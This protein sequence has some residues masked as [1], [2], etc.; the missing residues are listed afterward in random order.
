M[1]RAAR[2]ICQDRV[3]ITTSVMLIVNTLVTTLDSVPVKAD[4]APRTSLSSLLMSAPV[5]VRVKKAMGMRWMWENTLVRMSKMRPSP[6]R[7]EKSRSTR[8]SPASKKA[9]PATIRAR[10]TT[11]PLRWPRIP[12]LMMA[13]KMRGLAAESAASRASSEMSTTMA[14]R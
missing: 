1:T 12:S 10:A 3:S 4:C 8:E 6:M 14:R 11:S 7:E 9:M 5:C 2:V 13:R